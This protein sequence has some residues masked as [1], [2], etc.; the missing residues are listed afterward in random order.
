MCSSFL[1]LLTSSLDPRKNKRVKTRQMNLQ[2]ALDE[3]YIRIYVAHETTAC[4][5][6]PLFRSNIFLANMELLGHI[7]RVTFIILSIY[8]EIRKLLKETQMILRRKN[9]IDISGFLSWYMDISSFPLSNNF[10]C[11]YQLD[12]SNL[13]ISFQVISP[14][15]NYQQVI[16][17][18]NFL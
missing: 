12:A 11:K 8:Y 3:K 6:W 5:T 4:N 7:Y 17:L 15:S 1:S 9:A 14:K 10:P 13:L 16:I 2:G 18:F